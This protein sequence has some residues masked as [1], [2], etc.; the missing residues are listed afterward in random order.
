MSFNT[1]AVA[2]GPASFEARAVDTAGNMSTASGQTLSIDNTAPDLRI[3]SGPDGQTFAPG[4]TQIWTWTATDA[5]AGLSGLVC[6][7]DDGPWQ[8]CPSPWSVS[9]AAEGGHYIIVEALDAAGNF[10]Q[11]TRWWA[12]AAAVP[13]ATGKPKITGT[14]QPGKVLTATTGTWSGAPT[15]YAYSWQ[16]CSSSGSSCVAIETADATDDGD[17]ALTSADAGHTIRVKVTAANTAGSATGT[18]AAT[19]IVGLP[20][21]TIAPAISGTPKVGTQLKATTGTWTQSPSTYKYAWQRCSAAGSSC[22]AIGTADA[23]DDADYTPVAA[24]AGHAIKVVVTAKNAY[25][26]AKKA[27]KPTAAVAA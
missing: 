27:S 20:V 3:T 10:T 17:Y 9:G 11:Q 19:A 21:N 18:S 24:D 6:A 13:S 1:A 22:V 25:G 5:I 14:A 23:T 2:D 15:S 4:S 12:I 8:N 26:S 7:V 16:R